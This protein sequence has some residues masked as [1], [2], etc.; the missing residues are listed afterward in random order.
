MGVGGCGC[1]K[2][3]GSV[4]GKGVVCLARYGAA[5]CCIAG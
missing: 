2:L 3:M 4:C 1:I 5:C